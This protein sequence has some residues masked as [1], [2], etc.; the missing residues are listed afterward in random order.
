M[1]GHV[2]PAKQILRINLDETSV[3]LSQ[4]NAKGNLF[5]AKTKRLVQR[6]A[7]RKRRCC[8]THVAIICDHSEVQPLL[9]QILIGNWSAFHARRMAAL[10]AQCPPNIILIR[11]KSAWNNAKLC[12]GIIC[13]IAIAIEPFMDRF[14]PILLMDVHR[15]HTACRVLSA[16]IRNG[17]WPCFVPARLTCLLQPL[18]THGLNLYKAR[19]QE[20]YQ[21]AR[22]DSAGDE[23]TID[24]FLGCM[25]RVI[26][27]VLQGRHWSTAFDDDGF[28]QRQAAV[29][30]TVREHVHG[31]IDVSSE[32]PSL[33]DVAMCFPTRA[34]IPMRLLMSPFEIEAWPT[35]NPDNAASRSRRGFSTA[36]A[37]CIPRGVPLLPQRRVVRVTALSLGEESAA[38]EHTMTGVQ[39]G[40]RARLSR[41]GPLHV[42]SG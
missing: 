11:Q 20:E 36:A 41:L 28:G 10:R 3:C 6:I 22:I 23:L 17:I 30:R 31:T 26:R 42:P 18:D 16:S 12:A 13:R 39:T 2:P 34:D 15:I 35:C 33:H 27:F 9:P 19:L 24:E 37:V 32:R 14:Q 25:F 21:A 7:R 29:S 1:S 38:S 8:L 40:P 4:G 5:V